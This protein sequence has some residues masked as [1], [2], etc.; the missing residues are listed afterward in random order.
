MQ[1]FQRASLGDH[2][3]NIRPT[4]KSKVAKSQSA[5]L[6]FETVIRD[7]IS[8]NQQL[9]IIIHYGDVVQ[10]GLMEEYAKAT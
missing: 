3:A 8:L 1:G 2:C 4:Y 7:I 6:D 10:N 5:P 9:D